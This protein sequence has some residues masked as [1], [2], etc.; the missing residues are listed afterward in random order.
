[1]PAN[2]I[3]ALDHL[4]AVR[5]LIGSFLMSAS[6]VYRRPDHRA[7]RS[8]SELP[9][10]SGGM[11][12]IPVLSY[13]LLGRRCRYCA[14]PIA[15]RYMWVELLTALLCSVGGFDAAGFF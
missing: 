5:L 3:R 15:A 6:I 1:M 13:L 4:C 2:D 7:G 12:L 8:L 14:A 10:R 9:A 11:D